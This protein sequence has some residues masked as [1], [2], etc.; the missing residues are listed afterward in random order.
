MAVLVHGRMPGVTAEQYDALNAALHALPGNPFEGCL[1]HAAFV[2]DQALEVYDVW[3]SREAMEKFGEVV[4]P[5]LEKAGIP[6]TGAPQDV[7][8]LHNAWTPGS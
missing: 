2:R 8:E 5:L 4:M 6:V 1:S 3:E 7:V